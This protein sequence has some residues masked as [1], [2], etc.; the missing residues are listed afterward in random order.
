MVNLNNY[1]SRISD[2]S[3]KY[4]IFPYDIHKLIE[5]QDFKR[6]HR[7]KE[8]DLEKSLDVVERFLSTKY[9]GKTK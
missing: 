5:F 1:V 3:E 7:G 9:K 2:I 4:K 8:S 6:V